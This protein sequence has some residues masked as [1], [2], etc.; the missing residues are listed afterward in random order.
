MCPTISPEYS[1][2]NPW[3]CRCVYVCIYIFIRKSQIFHYNPLYIPMNYIPSVNHYKWPLKTKST[4]KNPQILSQVAGLIADHRCVPL[5][6]DRGPHSPGTT[7]CKAQVQGNRLRIK[8]G[9]MNEICIE[10]GT[11][12]INWVTSIAMFD[13]RMI[14]KYGMFFL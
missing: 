8:H 1:H 7:S 12:S 3:L 14:E 11:S 4:V 6:S 13:W 5:A 2:K 9:E 10:K